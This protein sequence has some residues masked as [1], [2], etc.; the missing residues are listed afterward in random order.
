MTFVAVPAPG[1][2]YIRCESC[3]DTYTA[4]EPDMHPREVKQ[5]ANATGWS[6]LREAGEWRHWCRIC[7]NFRKG[8]LL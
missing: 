8:R 3:P 4:P 5:L 7:T 6:A 1:L 2:S